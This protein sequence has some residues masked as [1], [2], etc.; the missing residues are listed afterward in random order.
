[1]QPAQQSR[2]GEPRRRRRC[3]QASTS[4]YVRTA[5][6]YDGTNHELK[7]NGPEIKHVRMK[8]S[9]DLNHADGDVDEQAA[10]ERGTRGDPAETGC[11]TKLSLRRGAAGTNAAPP[12]HH[13]H[14]RP[15]TLESPHFRHTIHH[16]GDIVDDHGGPTRTQREVPCG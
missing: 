16:Q 15:H 12:P 13:H 11:A 9:N 7:C 6:I 10:C 1:M 4:G 8:T 3:D 5:Y 2:T 14:P